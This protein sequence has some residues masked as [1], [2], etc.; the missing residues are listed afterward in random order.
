MITEPIDIY[1][2][3]RMA[4]AQSKNRPWRM[5]KDFDN[6]IAKKMSSS[7][8]E[9]LTLVT[10]YFNTKW[11]NVDSLDFFL[12]GFE[13]L[14]T[15]SYKNF[16]DKRVMNLYI[17]KDK[18]RKREM[19]IN[20]SSI[21]NS[22]TFIKEYIEKNNIKSIKQYGLIKNGNIC[23]ATDHYI[24]N[25]IDKYF[26]VKLI[27]SGVVSLTD[28]DRSLIPYIVEQYREILS[29]LNNIKTKGG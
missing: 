22:L 25:K 29:V 19:E 10:S 15:F 1:R 18:N 26:F 20:K 24:K 6:H 8:R 12:C 11:S 23:L 21:K 13:I 7:N 27:D 28:D 9:A 4:Q 5:P 16:F 3:F 14:K 17:I 2:F